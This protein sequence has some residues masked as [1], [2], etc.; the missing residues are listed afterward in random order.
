M[1]DSIAA[2]K[3][4]DVSGHVIQKRL[5]SEGFEIAEYK[6]LRD[7]EAEIIAAVRKHSDENGVDLIVTTGGTASDQETSH[8]RLSNGSSTKNYLELQNKSETTGKC[9]HHSRCYPDR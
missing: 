7:D 2:G 9:A 3:A 6:V 1:S 8:P 5:E 4:E